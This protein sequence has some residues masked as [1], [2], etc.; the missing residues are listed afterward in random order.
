MGPVAQLA[1]LARGAG[2]RSGVCVLEVTV[3]CSGDPLTAGTAGGS[4][5]FGV[6]ETTSFTAPRG[7]TCQNTPTCVLTPAARPPGMGS[8]EFQFEG[9][10]LSEKAILP[11]A[12][13]DPHES[14]AQY[15]PR[16]TAPCAP[17]VERPEMGVP[18]LDAVGFLLAFCT[19]AVKVLTHPLAATGARPTTARS[20]AARASI[21]LRGM[22]VLPFSTG[23]RC[24]VLSVAGRQPRYPSSR[25]HPLRG[26]GRERGTPF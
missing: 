18:M 11:A 24:S 25:R 15:S 3:T 5:S 12:P 7:T 23:E 20:P 10:P 8:C 21:D 13:V 16:T 22:A 9:S 4:L 26:S 6:S 19:V 2:P 17:V 14:L 1:A